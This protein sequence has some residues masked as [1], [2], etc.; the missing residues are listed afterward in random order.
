MPKE[1]ITITL[2]L[3]YDPQENENKPVNIFLYQFLTRLNREWPILELAYRGVKK[4]F[5]NSDINKIALRKVNSISNGDLPKNPGW[6]KD[7]TVLPQ[8]IKVKK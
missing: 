2:T 3:E 4:T 6:L 8:E 5:N 7:R 1:K